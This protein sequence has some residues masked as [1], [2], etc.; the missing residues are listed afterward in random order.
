MKY[1]LYTS[2]YPYDDY[3][4][5]GLYTI[6]DEIEWDET[7]ETDLATVI[8]CLYHSGDNEYARGE[9]DY[10]YD[11]ADEDG[12]DSRSQRRILTFLLSYGKDF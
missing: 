2:D 5:W 12:N 4:T 8:E 6:E 10:F 7:D 9:Q 11:D 3:D 1:W